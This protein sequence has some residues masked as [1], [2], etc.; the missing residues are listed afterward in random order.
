MAGEPVCEVPDCTRPP[1]GHTG[2]SARF[3]APHYN[4]LHVY[5]SA[6]DWVPIPKTLAPGVDESHVQRLAALPWT[7][8][9]N[10]CDMALDEHRDPRLAAMPDVEFWPHFAA[11]CGFAR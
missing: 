5:G 3:C 6:F 10:W 1:K 4:R 2:D 9:V 7:Q 11:V 8:L